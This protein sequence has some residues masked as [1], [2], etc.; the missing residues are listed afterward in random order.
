MLLFYV[1]LWQA[2]EPVQGYGAFTS[3]WEQQSGTE[4]PKIFTT[5][6]HNNTPDNFD[7]TGSASVTSKSL[8]HIPISLLVPDFGSGQNT[9][10]DTIITSTSIKQR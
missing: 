8:N 7:K 1:G 5:Y 6:V 9:S 4:T 3:Q 10:T 2:E